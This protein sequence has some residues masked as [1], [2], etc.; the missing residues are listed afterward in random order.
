M[1]RPS[2]GAGT[3]KK[4]RTKRVTTRRVPPD[5]RRRQLLDEAARIL[6]DEGLERLQVT[7]LA[8]RAGVSR[9]LVY[10]VFP[11]RHAL[12]RA[13][14][15]DFTAAIAERFQRALF[16][17]LPGTIESITTAFVEACCD[18]IDQK[19]A[20]PWLLLLDARGADPEVARIG[21]EV[22]GHLL[23]PWQERLAAFTGTPVR[24]A[25][26]YLWIIVAAGRAALAGWI[27]GTLSREEAV[28][29]AT[30]AVSAL[31]A[32]FQAPCTD[33]V[34]RAPARR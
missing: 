5:A 20:G 12:V 3:K 29:D 30:R 31:V 25:G 32:A 19:G 2:H 6:T 28:G 26:N 18:V 23:E 9:P 33:V 22:L 27:D 21:R 8:E 17:A 14:L 24:R 16:R 10:R 34:A 1:A 13:I 4:T 15:D 7:E 11:T